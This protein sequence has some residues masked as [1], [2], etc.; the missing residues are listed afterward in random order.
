LLIFYRVSDK[1]ATESAQALSAQTLNTV[2]KNIS[3]LIDIVLHVPGPSAVASEDHG[4]FQDSP[5]DGER[6]LQD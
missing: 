1:N 5:G 2:S 4:L 6:F 3:T